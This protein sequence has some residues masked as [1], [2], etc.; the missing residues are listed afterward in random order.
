MGALKIR[1]RKSVAK[2]GSSAP[3]QWSTHTSSF[4][5]HHQFLDNSVIQRNFERVL[6]ISNQSN[7]QMKTPQLNSKKILQNLAEPN[8]NVVL[9]A[10]SKRKAHPTNTQVAEMAL[11]I[12]SLP[13]KKLTS[14]PDQ[15]RQKLAKR[16]IKRKIIKL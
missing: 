4:N 9:S 11:G 7:T 8:T 5:M 16:Q 3:S 6:E 15:Q 12:N 14:K 1:S 13:E 2:N 10:L